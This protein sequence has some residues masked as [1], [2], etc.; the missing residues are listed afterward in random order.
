MAEQDD[1]RSEWTP[2]PDPTL[3]TTEALHREISALRELI[4]AQ[5]ALNASRDAATRELLGAK[6][7]ENG[8]LGDQRY[9]M[10]REMVDT[11][12]ADHVKLSASEKEA[13]RREFK[14]IIDAMTA[15][16]EK[17]ETVTTT[18]ITTVTEVIDSKTGGLGVEVR[19][20]EKRVD[21]DEGKGAGFTTSWAIV[22]A[23]VTVGLSA[24]ALVVA[25]V[26]A[27]SGIF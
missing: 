20:L 1:P 23:L 2:R 7:D 6:L 8:R 18:A 22:V 19:A 9:K 3:L 4:E 21:R 24:I 26:V 5:L 14:I 17:A 12:L 25:I 10:M 11:R 15:A 27:V 16:V 13:M